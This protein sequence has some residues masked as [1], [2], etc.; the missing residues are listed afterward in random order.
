[1][2]RITN[3]LA[4]IENTILSPQLW[5]MVEQW[6]MALLIENE[7][8]IITYVN[9]S[10]CNLLNISKKP[11]E[12]IGQ[13][14][15]VLV[16]ELRY[17]YTYSEEERKVFLSIVEDKK[18]V[19]NFIYPVQEDLILVIDFIPLL[20]EDKKGWYIWKFQNKSNSTLLHR[21]LEEKNNNYWAIIDKMDLGVLE[22]DNN[23]V[24]VRA[25]PQFCEMVGYTQDE[26]L[27]KIA[28]KILIPEDLHEFITGQ[29]K[30][31]V[32][33]RTGNYE[34]PLRKKN[35]Q[36]VWAIVN[37][38]PL[39]NSEG[40][41]SGSIGIHYDNT[42]RKILMEDLAKAKKSA[43][44][45][46]YAEKQF[47][48][49]MSHEIR[50]PLNA[51]V[52]MTHLLYDTTITEEQKEYI[53]ILKSSS[54]VLQN[55]LTDILDISA[56]ENRTL[57]FPIT[58]FDLHRLVYSLFKIFEIR[59]TKK[60]LTIT[61]NYDHTIDS[62]VEGNERAVYQILAKIINNAYKFTEKGS[63]E[64]I[65]KKWKQEGDIEVIQFEIKDTGFGIEEDKLE[66]IFDKFKQLPDD[67]GYK[68]QGVGLGLALVKQLV[69]MAGGTISV[70]TAKGTG[71]HFV[72]QI[73][74][75]KGQ[76]TGPEV[77]LGTSPSERKILVVDDNL[78]NRRY[79]CGLLD[80]QGY[81]YEIAIDGQMAVQMLYQQKYDLVLMDIQ[82]PF[83]DGYEATIII[84]STN[85]VNKDVPIIALTA[86]AMKE[87]TDHSL[88][89]GMNDFLTK[90]FTP[91]QFMEKIAYYV[92]SDSISQMSEIQWNYHS[93]LN[94]NYLH[95]LYGE[96]W[97]YAYEMFQTFMQDVL[98]EYSK[99]RPLLEQEDW[100]GLAREAHK[101]NPPLAMVGLTDLQKYLKKIEI[102]LTQEDK[103]DDIWEK[104]SYFEKELTRMIVILAQEVD[105]LAHKTAAP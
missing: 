82:M 80:K 66:L 2:K 105:R 45:A 21:A 72:L 94:Q 13:S 32:E 38:A 6:S 43:E 34:L 103:V 39:Y 67:T 22:V 19:E 100:K 4:S 77:S 5:K 90:P 65:V 7:E 41:V 96:E 63:I 58:N 70:S 56:I 31:R 50:T 59:N 10:Y 87:Q 49:N 48:A 74:F 20:N 26:L 8:R 95:E 51:I 25:Y 88:E 75:R 11:E 76:P 44:D 99:L 101:L 12:L 98:P 1:M 23:D 14:S 61:L 42:E 73:P 83:L 97:S 78:M 9:E 91:K 37:G 24:I 33:G 15:L 104:I 60:E 81:T 40:K 89:V 85:N 71:T 52:G 27:G 64:I 62:M 30:D 86:S 35:G 36:L 57:E 18:I 55:I 93:E 17:N 29:N 16:E 53:D 69:D 79:V 46:Q 54:T 68:F 92:S 3:A 47:L 84:R 102:Q 28:S